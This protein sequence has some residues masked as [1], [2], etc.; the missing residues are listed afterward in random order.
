MQKKE[1]AQLL[2][3]SASMVSRLAKRGMPTD[4]LERAQRWRKRHLEPG[5]VKGSR[6]GTEAP[7]P[8][9]TPAPATP[10][11]M[12]PGI[13][14]A[15]YRAAIE[16]AGQHLARNLSPDPV[17]REQQLRPL[18]GLLWLF[19]VAAAEPMA[20]PAPLWAALCDHAL[21]DAAP[22]RTMQD[23]RMP[24]TEAALFAVPGDQHMYWPDFFWLALGDDETVVPCNAPN[25]RAMANE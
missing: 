14:P 5:M 25:A 8:L 13:D 10:T 16:L 9:A 24:I 21:S 11:P 2:G 3:I 15:H 12:E 17:E 22:L 23:A 6:M 18:R 1:L 4:T 20:L 19:P 7:P